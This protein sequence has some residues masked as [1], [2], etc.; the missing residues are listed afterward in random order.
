MRWKLAAFCFAATTALASWQAWSATRRARTTQA[1]EAETDGGSAALAFAAP[2][3]NTNRN[4]D[5][6]ELDAVR[7]LRS[8]SNPPALAEIVPQLYDS[9]PR[10]VCAA[11]QAL[12][13]EQASAP[14]VELLQSSEHPPMRVRRVLLTTLGDIGDRR[15]VDALAELDPGHDSIFASDLAHALGRSGRREAIAPLRR[16]AEQH[17][18]LYQRE[19]IDGL[20]SLGQFEADRLIERWAEHGSSALRVAALESMPEPESPRRRRILAAALGSHITEFAVAAA[21]ALRNSRVLGDELRKCLTRGDYAS[22]LCAASLLRRGESEGI[23]DYLRQAGLQ[24]LSPR[25]GSEV[26]ESARQ[27]DMGTELVAGL[28]HEASGTDR[29]RLLAVLSSEGDAAATAEL[30]ETAQEAGAFAQL[31]VGAD[32]LS[33]GEPRGVD[34]VVQ[35]ALDGSSASVRMQAAQQLAVASAPGTREALRDLARHPDPRVS[36]PATIAI[37][38]NFDA[39]DRDDVLALARAVRDGDEQTVANVLS[40]IQNQDLPKP[41]QDALLARA[42]QEDEVAENA[43]RTL[44]QGLPMQDAV[45]VAGDDLNAQLQVLAAHPDDPRAREYFNRAQRTSSRAEFAEALVDNQVHT[46]EAR[47]F[48]TTVAA[49]G[50]TD[51]R[52]VAIEGLAQFGTEAEETL[53]RHTRDVDPGVRR[54]ALRAI[55]RSGSV[56]TLDAALRCANDTDVGTRRMAN[57]LVARRAWADPR[58]ADQLGIA[59]LDSDERIARTAART[60]AR[61]IGGASLEHLVEEVLGATMDPTRASVLASDILR[62]DPL[63]DSNVRAR[64]QALAN[65]P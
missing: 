7:A 57:Q 58:A 2:S 54:T 6:N 12:G 65:A 27:S 41:L 10:V 44:V 16:L 62:A 34:L 35:A 48:F 31:E 47:A 64:L 59:A 38:H 46:E 42:S 61:Q 53:L 11:I 32:L 22:Q 14:L 45:A 56:E 26:L 23:A 52:R 9:R 18:G 43:T 36:R 60:I 63:L 50:T 3:F 33:H 39:T 29:L 4:S 28:L 8:R 51:E 13:R 25:M 1:R 5:E 37:V 15:S 24:I 30:V 19:A 49:R 17:R 21:T 40:A 55:G 20:V